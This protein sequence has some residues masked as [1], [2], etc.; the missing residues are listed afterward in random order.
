MAVEIKKSI[1]EAQIESGMKKK[2]LADHYGLPMTQMT[3]VLQQ[4]GLRIKQNHHPKFV[5]VDDTVEGETHIIN[6]EDIKMNPEL[7]DHGIAV[8]DVVTLGEPVTNVAGEESE[9]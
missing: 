4:L 6:S 9:W 8:G 5:I 1:I 2:E 3:K 7:V